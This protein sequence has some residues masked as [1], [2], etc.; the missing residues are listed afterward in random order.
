VV[1]NKSKGT[2]TVYGELDLAELE[3]ASN[4]PAAA[5]NDARTALNVATSLQG[6]AP[7]SN[8]SGLSWLM[9]GRALQ[10]RGDVDNAR[11][12][13]ASAVDN[14]SNTVDAAHLALIDARKMLGTR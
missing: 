11:L 12:A 8:L 5:E 7:H 1:G 4:N 2:P 10:S 6:V 13:F 9:L 3:L 14:L